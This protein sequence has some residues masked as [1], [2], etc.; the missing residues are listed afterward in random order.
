MQYRQEQFLR[1]FQ[2]ARRF[3]REHANALGNYANAPAR[4]KLDS[5]IS[6]LEAAFEGQVRTEKTAMALTARKHELRHE[7][8][9]HHLRILVSIAR[10]ELGDLDVAKMRTFT[11]PRIRAYDVALLTAARAI[12]KAAAPHAAVFV[13]HGAERSFLGELDAAID[14]L[15]RCIIARDRELLEHRRHVIA[16]DLALARG[17]EAL[18][19]LGA[20][21]QSALGRK[22]PDLVSEWKSAV[23][24]PA[25]P[26]PARKR[27][28]RG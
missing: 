16:V 20:L 10:A 17:R 18:G 23:R 24:I 27:R 7:L 2:R 22:R 15:E 14:A 25:K 11:V 26:G 21:V 3:Y 19:I 12:R 9:E 8:R 1:A 13:A 5:S 4:K 6:Q 28:A